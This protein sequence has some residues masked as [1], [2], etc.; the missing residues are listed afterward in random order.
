MR[1]NQALRGH[2]PASAAAGWPLADVAEA[3]LTLEP[4]RLPAEGACVHVMRRSSLV[5]CTSHERK[6]KPW[7]VVRIDPDRRNK[8]KALPKADSGHRCNHNI[9]MVDD[10]RSVPTAPAVSSSCTEL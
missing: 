7:H 9:L 10:L 3:V 2:I 1:Y 6:S 8:K 5:P 4:L